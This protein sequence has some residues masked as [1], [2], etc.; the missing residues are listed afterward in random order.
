MSPA[1]SFRSIQPKAVTAESSAEAVRYEQLP[2]PTIPHVV[3]AT[4]TGLEL[5]AWAEQNRKQIDTL[6]AEHG[7]LLFRDFAV[8]PQT[9]FPRF[10]AAVG[11][12]SLDYTQRSTRRTKQAKGVYTSTE[13][14][15]PLTI[16]QHSENAFQQSWPQRIMFHSVIVAETQGATPIADNAL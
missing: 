13:Y 9:G 6:L 14:P 7:A 10:A 15:A 2:G 8:A 12:G 3:R 11:G 1:P 4:A 16:E 5:G